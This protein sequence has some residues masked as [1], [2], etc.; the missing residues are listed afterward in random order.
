MLSAEQPA[1]LRADSARKRCRPIASVAGG[2][3]ATRSKPNRLESNAPR[4]AEQCALDDGWR[5]V[6]ADGKLSAQFEHTVAVTRDGVRVLTLRP[7][8]GA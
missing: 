8:E 2:R 1:S 6:T 5:V 3:T 7:E 4:G